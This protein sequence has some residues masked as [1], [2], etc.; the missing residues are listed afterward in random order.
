MTGDSNIENI[1]HASGK[2]SA[3]RYF[4]DFALGETILHAT[5]RTVSEGDVSLYTALT[6]S[7]FVLQSSDAFAQVVGL[8][9][10]PVDNLL[11]FHIAFGKTVPDISLNAVANLGYA[12]CQF[13]QPVYPG[14]TLAVASEVI[15]LRATQD[16]K[17]GIVYVRS[18]AKNQAG[19][20]VLTWV[21]WVMVERRDPNGSAPPAQV[22]ELDSH[23]TNLFL[24]A[25]LTAE[26]WNDALAGS[27]HRWGDYAAGERIDH[28]AGLTVE[29]TEHGL[30][31]KLYQNNARVHFN[32]QRSHGTRFGQRVVY[33]GHVM[34]LA[35]A[36]SFN[37]LGNACLV[38]AI[39]AGSHVNPVFPGDTIYAWTEITD[40]WPI[41][42][43]AGFGALHL[44]TRATKDLPCE[45]FP[46]S[47]LRLVL[48]LD[49]SVLI[50]R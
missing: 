14:D 19:D 23:V 8:P 1:A 38:G 2:A 41:Q 34:S 37:G 21:R 3:G 10:A 13:L 45:S 5:P 6:G 22:P 20:L 31:A 26:T 33:G 29:N 30:A 43:N 46:K 24:P 32:A 17:A 25:T 50:P 4:E 35:R 15:G 28:L 44:R 42:S 12:E 49:Y 11:V 39:N 7:R 36:L 9:R 16:G 47:G 27:A 48:D 18:N 40:K